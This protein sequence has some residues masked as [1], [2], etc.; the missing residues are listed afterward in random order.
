MR[1]LDECYSVAKKINDKNDEIFELKM[2]I[3]SPKNQII[4]DMPRGGN[5]EN[6]IE[7][8]L[9]KLE[10]LQKKI[11]TLETQRD[12]IWNRAKEIM[13]EYDI[14]GDKEAVSMLYFRYYKGFPW[15]EC[16][17]LLMIG[18]KNSNWNENK[19]FRVHRKILDKIDNMNV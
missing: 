16:A 5:P 8:Y 7:N 19:C 4:T 11:K 1:E 15:K 13:R 9:F 12:L 14:L 10:R 3:G 6:A 17:R 2:K 18:Y